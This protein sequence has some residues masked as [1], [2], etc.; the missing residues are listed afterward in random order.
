[1]Q[2]TAPRRSPAELKAEMPEVTEEKKKREKL[3]VCTVYVTS[4]G[5]WDRRL[6]HRAVSFLWEC[7][8]HLTS[9]TTPGNFFL[10]E[11][12]EWLMDPLDNRNH[13]VYFI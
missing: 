6:L 3:A 7:L 12:T 13:N 1:M 5:N 10:K 11:I 9:L 2:N 8:E 4:D